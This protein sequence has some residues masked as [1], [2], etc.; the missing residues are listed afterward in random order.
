MSRKLTKKN[1]AIDHAP[2]PEKS[3]PRKLKGLRAQDPWL[4]REQGRYDNP[5]PSREF[6]LQLLTEAGAPVFPDD[7]KKQLA[8]HRSES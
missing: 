1:E 3:K 6:I 4:E 8:I 5:L 2:A 7:L